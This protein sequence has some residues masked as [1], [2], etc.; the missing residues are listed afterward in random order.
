MRISSLALFKHW[1]NLN[2]LK[3]PL[4]VIPPYDTSQVQVSRLGKVRQE[5][6]L[7]VIL[8]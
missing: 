1:L 8:H 6:R 5:G 7:L 2:V 4:I 3:L